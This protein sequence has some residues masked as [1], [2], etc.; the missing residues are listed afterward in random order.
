LLVSL[1]KRSKM[2]RNVVVVDVVPL[3]LEFECSVCREPG[4]L[5]CSAA[6]L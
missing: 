2:L 4:A 3:S 1:L 5:A 6:S